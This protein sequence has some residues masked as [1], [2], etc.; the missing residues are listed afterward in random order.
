MSAFT[1]SRRGAVGRGAA[2]LGL[3]WPGSARQGA[4]NRKT[5]F[6]L[7]AKA[8]HG[9]AWQGGVWHGKARC[10]SVHPT[11]GWGDGHGDDREAQRES[12]NEAGHKRRTPWIG[13]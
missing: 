2:R 4:S 12:H 13:N 5:M 6:F 10:F 8:R 1:S 9:R 11:N 3:V 7:S